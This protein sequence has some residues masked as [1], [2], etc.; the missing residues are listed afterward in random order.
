MYTSAS[1]VFIT[2]A[3][4]LPPFV[5]FPSKKCDSQNQMQC[6]P[7]LTTTLVARPPNQ[8][9]EVI[10]NTELNKARDQ[11]NKLSQGTT[12]ECCVFIVFLCLWGWG[13]IQEVVK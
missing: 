5:F 9:R 1:R 4:F 10:Q 2:Q 6:T 8:A 7:P 3:T 12:A 13:I 11:N